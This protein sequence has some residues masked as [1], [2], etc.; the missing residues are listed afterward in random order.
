MKTAVVVFFDIVGFSKFPSQIQ[1]K[2]IESATKMVLSLLEALINVKSNYPEVIALP[3][4][5]GMAIAFIRNEKQSWDFD[6]I[7]NLI[8]FLQEWA[9]KQ[10]SFGSDVQ[11]RIGVH[12]GP[13]EIIK[14]V[15]HRVNVCGHTINFTQ[16]VMDS[17]N[18]K[19]VLFSDDAFNELVGL[20]SP[21]YK[22]SKGY[23]AS[24]EGPY[25]V[26]AKHN[27]PLLVRKCLINPIQSWWSSEDPISKNLIT[28]QLT[29]LPK[30]I[31]GLFSDRI[32][33]AES[34]ALI[35][36]TGD[37]L[38]EKLKIGEV[39]L[40][41]KLKQFLV[42]MP[43]SDIYGSMELPARR[44]IRDYTKNCITAWKDY[45]A[46]LKQQNDYCIIKLGLFKQPPYFGAS[47]IDWQKLHGIIHVSPYVWSLKTEDCPGYNLEWLGS[48]PPIAYERYVVGLDSLN[49]SCANLIDEDKQ[50]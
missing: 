27:M 4:G 19:Q 36:L 35:Q 25:Q 6:K 37:R 34:I 8:Y 40:S 41:D 33:D 30:Q 11:L 42:F 45:L 13:I 31:M 21:K 26:M 9:S 12:T 49:A 44:S 18:A 23:A 50:K 39:Q 48:K 1:K 14:D 29:S 3:T 10:S 17:A 5:D 38:L 7:M 43:D 2:L 47:F 16:R 28:V 24:F 22:F 46:N 15:N 20:A 32:S